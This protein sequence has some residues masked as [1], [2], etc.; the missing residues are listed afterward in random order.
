[1]GLLTRSRTNIVLDAKPV[2]SSLSCQILY[3]SGSS[4]IFLGVLI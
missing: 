1:M 3:G 2:R 4:V